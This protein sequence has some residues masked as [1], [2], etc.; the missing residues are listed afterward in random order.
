[1]FA[2][3]APCPTAVL[4]PPVVSLDNACAPTPVLLSP[5]VRSSNTSLPKPVLLEA[6][7]SVPVPASLLISIL[8][9]KFALGPVIPAVLIVLATTRVLAIS[10][11]PSIS[12]TSRLAVPSTSILPETFKAAAVVV[13]VKSRSTKA[14]ITAAPDP[15]P[16]N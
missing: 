10:T 9:T 2:S 7:L 13:P 3:N 5:L 8:P 11:A 15:A 1:M 4:A 16:S 14:S 12:T 6:A